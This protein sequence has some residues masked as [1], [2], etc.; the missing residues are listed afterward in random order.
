MTKLSFEV[1]I[2]HLK[3]F[4]QYQDYHFMLSILYRSDSYYQAYHDSKP[5]EKKWPSFW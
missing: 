5:R 1:P 2:P 4:D 3:D